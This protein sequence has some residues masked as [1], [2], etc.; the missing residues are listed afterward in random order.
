MDKLPPLQRTTETD[1]SNIRATTATEF[2]R[3]V[4]DADHPVLVDFWADWCAPCH[5]LA[6]TLDQLAAS[7]DDLHV[8]KVNVDDD[9]ELAARYKVRG[10]PSL[11]LFRDG[12]PA[13]THVGVANLHQLN[14]W[15]DQSIAE[16]IAS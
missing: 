16:G 14:A 10:I 6:P 11:V 7:R 4:L 15:L 1:M 2:E 12:E 8:L 9:K 3:D 13:A 5:A